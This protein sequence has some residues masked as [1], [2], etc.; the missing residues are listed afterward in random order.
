MHSFPR[1]N[2]DNNDIAFLEND[3][4]KHAIGK[5]LC[6]I[7]KNNNVKCGVYT[8]TYG[9]N[10]I[11]D[12]NDNIVKYITLIEINENLEDKQ[13]DELVKQVY[14]GIIQIIK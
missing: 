14:N 3:T 5:K 7:L 12:T 2:F 13:L 4:H 1:P 11:I 6:D 9:K 8:S 10:T